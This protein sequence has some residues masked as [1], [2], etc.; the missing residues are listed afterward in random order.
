MAELT[1]INLCWEV[2]GFDDIKQV[3]LD[4]IIY[5]DQIIYDYVEISGVAK[6]GKVTHKWY[7]KAG[8]EWVLMSTT[9]WVIPE[10]W[11]SVWSTS[12]F[13]PPS[14]WYKKVVVEYNGEYLGEIEFYVQPTSEQFPNVC[15]APTINASI[16]SQTN[17][18][19]V[20]N[21]IAL[22]GVKVEYGPCW[23]EKIQ[24]NWVGYLPELG[25]F[26]HTKTF[27]KPGTYVVLIKAF[28]SDGKVAQINLKVD[29]TVVAPPV[30]PQ[31]TIA[32]WM[33]KGYNWDEANKI[34]VWV[35]F[36]KMT[37]T[38]EQIKEILKIL[39]D[40][41]VLPPPPTDWTEKG[42]QLYQQLDAAMDQDNKVE[43]WRIL[44]E[45]AKTEMS[46]IV[47]LAAL[48]AIV[49]VVTLLVTWLGSI[50]FA[51]F[52][53]EET[54]QALDFAIFQA[55]EREDW[56]AMGKLL[57][58]KKE[59]LDKTL[60]ENIISVIPGVNII[61]AAWK[62][63]DASKL[64]YEIDKKH[65]EE[66]IEA[67]VVNPDISISE[68]AAAIERGEDPTQYL[69]SSEPVTI[70]EVISGEVTAVVDGD[71][72]EVTDMLGNVFRIRLIGIDAPEFKTTA[73]KASGKFLTDQIHGKRVEVKVDPNNKKDKY[74]RVLGV[75]FLGS[76]DINRRMLEEGH[77]NYYF[78]GSSKYYSDDDYKDAAKR[79]GKV[80]VYSKP[81]YCKIWIDQV[82]TGKLAIE[83]FD[84][85]EGTYVIG[86]S[87]EGYI[88]KSETVTVVPDELL[89]LR[90]EL[91]A[92]G[93]GEEEP[94]VPPDEV[95][96]KVEF[97]IYITSTPGNAK[98]FIDDQYTGHWTPSNERELSDVIHLFTVG[99]HRIKATKAG[100][101]AEKEIT[102]VEGDNGTHELV[103]ET[104]GLPPE[105]P[106]KLPPE[107]EPP[108]TPPIEKFKIYF[109]ST[110]SNA[111]LFIDDIYTHHW[112]PSDE[113]EL[114]DVL[115]LLTVGTHRIKVTKAGM[116]GEKTITIFSG[117]NGVVHIDL[118]TIG[119]PPPEEPPEVVVP[120]EVEPT[121]KALFA[122]MINLTEDRKVITRK[123]VEDL[124]IVYGVS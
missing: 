94:E 75:V 114:S 64:K 88:A 95:P 13:I 16:E 29:T 108:I 79:R 19:V 46:P 18:T 124:M 84:L 85:A 74:D 57:A 116:I 58:M 48:A 106:P 92:T 6:G 1:R 96:E 14:G 77:A 110:P 56:V 113:R 24:F 72:I 31:E 100:M 9:D 118:E 123:E 32:F 22:P 26:P 69:P 112:T 109:T 105:E 25:W 65:W 2:K 103:L 97:K 10:D 15:E 67:T 53:M 38:P 44:R 21:G 122:E 35:K 55:S 51:E 120:P 47:V 70:P 63:F 80:K 11:T 93:L 82:D 60:W 111:K 61:A 71:T 27:E 41:N 87:K 7:H 23:I 3:K 104:V 4:D 89:E 28:Q 59:V 90:F 102:I 68:A 40:Y 81:T 66:Q 49:K 117:D 8:D 12:G 107:E 115:E 50:A 5:P 45:M 34:V 91:K 30:I 54:L 86:C 99:K 76:V 73:G 121:L 52:L 36:N 83:T 37:P 33:E 20:I 119:L 43:G 101:S 78:I 98:L 42:V 39:Y 62:F 17:N